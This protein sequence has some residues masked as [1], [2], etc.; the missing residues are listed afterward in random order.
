[1]E[2]KN[3]GAIMVTIFFILTCAIIGSC[4]MAFVYPEKKVTVASP[5]VTAAEGITVTDKKGQ[6]VQTIELSKSKL[7]LK[8][9][10][11]KENCDTDIPSTVTDRTGSEGVYGV[12]KIKSTV[13][14]KM[15][16]TDVKVETKAEPGDQREHI[17]VALKDVQK[18]CQNLKEDKI[19]LTSGESGDEEKEFTL[20]VWLHSHAGN[21]FTGAKI[22]FNIVFEAA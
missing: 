17:Q 13:A 1:M 7:G 2:S 22:S 5:R 10:T 6:T 9:V 16:V 21:E 3:T 14:W 8:P 12:F 18:S 15:Y 20:L 11:G 19:L 4:F